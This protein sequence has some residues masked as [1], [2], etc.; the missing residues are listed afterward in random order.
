MRH[1]TIKLRAMGV[2]V[3][4]SYPVTVVT[5]KYTVKDG[6]SSGYKIPG[7]KMHLTAPTFEAI[8]QAVIL[9]EGSADTPVATRVLKVLERTGKLV[10]DWVS[11]V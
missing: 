1:G 11:T 7:Y 5:I 2:T 10:A 3:T 4:A 9:A 8:G 6:E